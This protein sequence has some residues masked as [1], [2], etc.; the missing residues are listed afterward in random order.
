M[1]SLE[2]DTRISPP[3][4]VPIAPPPPAEPLPSAEDIPPPPPPVD[5]IYGHTIDIRA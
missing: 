3:L 5:D 2:I 1:S 4:E